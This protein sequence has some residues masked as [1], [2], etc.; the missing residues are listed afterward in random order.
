MSYPTFPKASCLPARLLAVLVLSAASLGAQP[1]SSSPDTPSS[2]ALPGAT[3]PNTITSPSTFTTPTTT[4]AEKDYAVEVMYEHDFNADLKD[5]ASGSM[6]SN[7]YELYGN[8]SFHLTNQDRLIIGADYL[9]MNYEFD[10]GPAPFGNVQQIGATA[11][12]TH[13]FNRQWGAFGY[14]Y[15]GFAAETAGSLQDGDQ[16]ALAFGPTVKVTPELGLAFGPMYYSRLEDEGAW[17]LLVDMGWNFLPQWNLHVYT[18]IANGATVSYDLFNNQATVLDASLE[19]NSFWFRLRDGP[20]GAGQ[21]VDERDW[22]LRFGVRQKLSDN[23]FVR[24][25]VAAIFDREYHFH[26]NDSSAGSFKV[27]STLGV[28]V[29]LG[30]AF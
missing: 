28:G 11:W 12:Y 23:F 20:G 14:L 29:E 13:D 17:T 9:Y 18:G 30:A 4:S 10:G 16:G 5:G 21:A 2:P 27:D 19:Y 15:G 25:Y 26:V 24:G 1:T 7:E 3:V 22:A 8:Y 6:R